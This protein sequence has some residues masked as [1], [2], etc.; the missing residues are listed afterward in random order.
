MTPLDGAQPEAGVF[1]DAP[2]A[3]PPVADLVAGRI[4]GPEAE[5]APGQQFIL[6]AST[7]VV[8]HH[9]A[10]LTHMTLPGGAAQGGDLLSKRGKAMTV[11]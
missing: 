4:A 1:I 8:P 2:A 9:T 11:L 7:I 10:D 6:L 5:V 3:L